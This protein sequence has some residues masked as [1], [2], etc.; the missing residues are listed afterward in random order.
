MKSLSDVVALLE[1][2]KG[3]AAAYNANPTA[4]A[5]LRLKPDQRVGRSGWTRAEFDAVQIPDGASDAERHTALCTYWLAEWM[6]QDEKA[7]RRQAD[8]ELRAQW[9]ACG[10]P[11]GYR[12][13][14]VDDFETDTPERRNALSHVLAFPN[15]DDE[16]VDRY[17]TLAMLGGNGTGKSTL[18]VLW[19]EQ[20]HFNEVGSTCWAT[21][22][23][24]AGEG[25]NAVRNY[26]DV[27]FLVIDEMRAC[28]SGDGV[29]VLTELFEYRTTNRGVTCF[30]S[31]MSLKELHAMF[32]ARGYSRLMDNSLTLAFSGPDYRLSRSASVVLA[33]IDHQAVST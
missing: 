19:L 4:R 15:T 6:R 28:I 26:G 16:G 1:K 20:Q 18:A 14:K 7:T 24:I 8:I 12:G 13:K 10:V 5:S 25:K 2:R 30:T 29:E 3:I 11:M 27:D 32:G 9:R 23:A 33:D 22:K 17:S 31:N 21:A